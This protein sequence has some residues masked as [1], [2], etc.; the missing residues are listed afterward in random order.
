[1]RAPLFD[2]QKYRD[3]PCCSHASPPISRTP[4]ARP[5]RV[6]SRALGAHPTQVHARCGRLEPRCVLGYLRRETCAHNLAGPT[7][8]MNLFQAINN[9]MN[10]TLASDPTAGMSEDACNCT[11]SLAVVFGE[12]VAFGGV[13]RCTIDL[14]NQFGM[15][16]ILHTDVILTT[17]RRA[18]SIQ[19]AAV[20]ARHSRVWHWTCI[21][22]CDL[23]R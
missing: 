19:H 17:P 2:K 11:H 5:A 6:F 1:M 12:D 20:R 15:C 7:K 9:A 16:L 18:A 13:F 14:R 21:K 23:D 22:R 3:F 8:Q 4:H 10:I